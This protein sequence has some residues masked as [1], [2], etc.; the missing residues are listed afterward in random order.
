ME[1]KE[2][3]LEHWV[4]ASLAKAWVRLV[5]TAVTGGATEQQSERQCRL[6]A[7]PPKQDGATEWRW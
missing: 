4:H 2:M 6:V 3:G 7:T 5:A 1:W